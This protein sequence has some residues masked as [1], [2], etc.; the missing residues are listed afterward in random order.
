MREV[1]DGPVVIGRVSSLGVAKVIVPASNG[2][3]TIRDWEVEKRVWFDFRPYA[4][5]AVLKGP[6]DCLHMCVTPH[7]H[8]PTPGTLACTCV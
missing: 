1:W 8:P 7:Q 3:H 5:S 4:S 6:H 2:L